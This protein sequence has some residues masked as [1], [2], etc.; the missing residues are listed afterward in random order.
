MAKKILI[1][2]ILG[3]CADTVYSFSLEEL[4]PRTAWI[5]ALAYTL[6]IYY[7]FSGYSD[8]AIG[9]GKMFG[10]SIQENFNYPYISASIAEFWRRW[11][12][13]LGSWFREYVYIPLGGN[14]KGERR[15][16]VNLIIVF[17]LTGLWHGADISFILWGLYH[18]TF[19]LVERLGLKKYLDRHR[20]FGRIYCFFVVNA[21]WVL[22][23]SSHTMEAV[24]YLVRMMMPWRYRI[25]TIPLWKFADKRT[26]FIGICAVFGMGI[27]QKCVPKKLKELWTESA[28][29]AVWCAFLLVLC[30]ASTASNTYS[31]FIYFQF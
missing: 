2:N 11:H 12:I 19:Q 16:F 22:F 4:D 29:E 6:Q 1:A 13:S 9:L 10:F 7:D 18:G 28:L 17:F 23:R 3:L 15:T 5:G 24:R 26:W 27:L 30:L 8:M 25:T 21:G 20:V 14:R 31:P